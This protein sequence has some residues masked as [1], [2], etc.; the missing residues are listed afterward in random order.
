M[1]KRN[2]L[3]ILFLSIITIACNSDRLFEEANLKKE[4]KLNLENEA[5]I[6]TE[7][8]NLDQIKIQVSETDQQANVSGPSKLLVNVAYYGQGYT[9]LEA[10][11]F[12]NVFPKLEVLHPNQSVGCITVTADQLVPSLWN[13][14]NFYIQYKTL[15]LPTPVTVL[16][17][18]ALVDIHGSPSCVCGIGIDTKFLGEDYSVEHIGSNFYVNTETYQSY[19]LL[20]CE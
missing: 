18:G 6:L 13:P 10:L 20:Y 7:E 16:D 5:T 8:S 14:G 3:F 9:T 17:R 19:S 2:I 4:V 15:D 11:G 12:V 1:K